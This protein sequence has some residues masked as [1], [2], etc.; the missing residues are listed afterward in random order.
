MPDVYQYYFKYLCNQEKEEQKAM[1]EFLNVEST[2]KKTQTWADDIYTYVLLSQHETT[3]QEG[4]DDEITGYISNYVQYTHDEFQQLITRELK[5]KTITELDQS[6]DT[7]RSNKIIESKR[8]LEKYYEEH[9]LFS[10]VHKEEGEFYAVTSEKQNYLL[11]MIALCEQSADLGVE[12]EPTWN[13]TGEPCEPWTLTE[14]KQLALQIAQCVYPAVSKQQSYEKQINSLENTEE[15][16]SMVI[17]Y[18]TSEIT[19]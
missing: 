4:T 6:L 2:V 12:F 14:L 7:V 18:E 19:E 9:P 10:T 17:D 15:I 3:L 13:A 16:Q 8:L 1:K 5:E 11:S